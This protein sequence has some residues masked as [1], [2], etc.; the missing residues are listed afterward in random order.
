M[1]S[2]KKKDDF[3]EFKGRG[4]SLEEAEKSAR[5]QY[6]Q[7]LNKPSTQNSLT[8]KDTKIS[9]KEISKL[10]FKYYIKVIFEVKK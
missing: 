8:I 6:E 4:N 3:I 10:Y 1:F 5:I 9:Q 2:F 7:W